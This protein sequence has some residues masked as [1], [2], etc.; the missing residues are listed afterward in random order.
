MMK[1][2]IGLGSNI[3][4]RETNLLRAIALLE[5]RGIKIVKKSSIYETFPVGYA[6]QP[7]FLNQVLE[8]QSGLEPQE[9]LRVILSIEK[10]MGRS[11]SSPN[12]PRCI[13]IDILLAGD[14]I[15]KSARLNIPHPELGNRNFVLVP[16][17]EIA[18][19]VIHPVFGKRM[20]ELWH[21]SEDRSAVRLYIPAKNIALNS[22]LKVP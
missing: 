3:G 8:V 7:W 6:E 21:R 17:K 4:E 12:A 10:K 15:I 2:H 19:D 9:L 13:D 22:S 1:Y 5:K 14:R 18:F 20:G 11:R 16:L